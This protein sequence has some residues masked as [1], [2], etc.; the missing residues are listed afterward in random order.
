MSVFTA[1]TLSFYYCSS[2]IQLEI[3]EGDTFFYVFSSQ[4]WLFKFFHMKFE[5][6]TF[7]ISVKNCVE[8]F[9]GEDCTESANWFW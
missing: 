1:V 8:L 3:W 5:D 4:D 9:W 7:F 6:C 2:V